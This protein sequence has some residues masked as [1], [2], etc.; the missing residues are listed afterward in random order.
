MIYI[1]IILHPATSRL[2]GFSLAS[3]WVKGQPGFSRYFKQY[4]H[5]YVH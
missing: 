3:F 1:D 4:M 5:V 2:W